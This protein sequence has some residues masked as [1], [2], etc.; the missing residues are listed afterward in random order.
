V[1]PQLRLVCDLARPKSIKE[2]RFETADQSKRRFQTAAP[3]FHHVITIRQLG[4]S[5]SHSL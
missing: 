3:W 1:I 4:S 2:R 5:V